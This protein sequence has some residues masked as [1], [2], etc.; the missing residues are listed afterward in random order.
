[1]MI[2]AHSL[3]KQFQSDGRVIRAVD[4][5][6]FSVRPGEV[7]GLLGPNGAGKTT[8]MRMILGLIKP[9]SG[10][11]EID[12]F[13]SDRDPDEIKRR[14][15][16][17]SASAGVYQWLSA[18]EILTFFADVYGLAP[19]E[20]EPRISALGELLGISPFLDQRCATLSTG[21]R[22]RVNLARA[23]VHDPPLMIM[24]EPTLGLDVVGSQVVFDYISLLKQQGKA[25]ILCT[26]QLEQ[27]QRVCDRFGLLFRSRL[28]H[29]GTLDELR[30]Q[31]GQ[32]DLVEMFIELIKEPDAASQPATSPSGKP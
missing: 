14:V 13:R 28:I 3:C 29:E 24:D 4:E 26:H 32:A 1:M 6:S 11:A 8:T 20:I 19:E 12:G 21:Q 5:V 25:V 10:H 30:T 9:D 16:F 7:Y 15:G 17:V 23:L 31:T 27:A 2:S 18:R 22:Q